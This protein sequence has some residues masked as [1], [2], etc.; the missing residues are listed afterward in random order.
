M[1]AHPA[2]SQ[3]PQQTNSFLKKQG[4]TKHSDVQQKSKVLK[5]NAPKNRHLKKQHIF[6]ELLC[7]LKAHLRTVG[8][9]S[10]FS[11]AKQHPT[12]TIKVLVENYN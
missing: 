1:E 3:P 4:M 10:C 11:P 5:K 6:L 7:G 2:H 8:V 9:D 12:V